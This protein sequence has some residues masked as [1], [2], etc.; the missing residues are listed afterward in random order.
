MLVLPFSRHFEEW[1]QDKGLKTEFRKPENLSGILNWMIQGLREYRKRGLAAPDA[2]KEA[3]REYRKDSDKLS[4]FLEDAVEENLDGE[5]RLTL[6]YSAYKLWCK[7]NGQYAES[8]RVF[9]RG[10][11]KTG[12]QIKR[13]RPVGRVENPTDFVLGYILI[14]DYLLSVG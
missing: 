12:V 5:I 4:R 10:L 2:I 1:E 11:E 6:L 8:N 3:T 7:E 14:S 9:R 13:K